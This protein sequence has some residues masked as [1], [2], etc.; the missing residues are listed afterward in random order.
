MTF[1]FG[2][3]E[4]SRSMIWV[5]VSRPTSCIGILGRRPDMFLKDRDD[6][7]MHGRTAFYTRFPC[8]AAQPTDNSKLA[9]L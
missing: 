5:G 6:A 9:G 4:F 3:Y 2:I 8:E 7:A 1:L